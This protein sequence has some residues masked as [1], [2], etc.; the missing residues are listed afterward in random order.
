MA[1][2]ASQEDRFTVDDLYDLSGLVCTAW[3][4][5]VDRDWSVPAGTLEWSCTKTADHAVDCVWAPAFFLASRRQ[6]RYPDVGVDL[7][8]GPEADPPHLVQSLE[9][10]TRVLGAVVNDAGPEVRAVI[11]R[12]PEV[13]TAPP[14]DFPPRAAME[15]ILHAHDVCAG[16]QIPFEPPAGMCHRLREHTRPWSMWRLVWDAPGHT[17]D[18]WGDLLTAS[19][20]GRPSDAAPGL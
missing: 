17:G 18:P 20:R 2:M 10:A 15:L 4:R 1:A 8:L 14:S 13:R 11:F 6:D 7:T 19:G 3:M 9:I 12:R 16:L 5:A